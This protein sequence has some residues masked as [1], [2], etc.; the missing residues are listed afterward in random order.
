MRVNHIKKKHSLKMILEDFLEPRKGK[1][2]E[3]TIRQLEIR[4]S[5]SGSYVE[6]QM[7]RRK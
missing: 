7:T 3:G 5:G 4:W 2:A 6:T 1:V